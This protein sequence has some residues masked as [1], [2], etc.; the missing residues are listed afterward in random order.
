MRTHVHYVL[1]STAS[2][3]LETTNCDVLWPPK[4]AVRIAASTAR[5]NVRQS[6][7]EHEEQVRQCVL[8]TLCGEVVFRNFFLVKFFSVFAYLR[9]VGLMECLEIRFKSG[10][11]V[12]LSTFAGSDCRTSCRIHVEMYR[13]QV[14]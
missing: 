7:K 6:R 8:R 12:L 11:T 1:I 9:A 3:F 4:I 5:K 13:C 2:F 10:P 14:T